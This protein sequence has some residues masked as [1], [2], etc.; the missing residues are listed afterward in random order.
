MSQES[1]LTWWTLN[2]HYLSELFIVVTWAIWSFLVSGTSRILEFFRKKKYV[3]IPLAITM[4]YFLWK[5]SNHLKFRAHFAPSFFS[6]LFVGAYT[7]LRKKVC[8]NWLHFEEKE[9]LKPLKKP[10]VYLEDKRAEIATIELLPHIAIFF[11][12]ENLNFRP[13]NLSQRSHNRQLRVN[14]KVVELSGNNLRKK[15]SHSVESIGINFW[16][17]KS[18][19][20]WQ[21][22]FHL[23]FSCWHKSY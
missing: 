13:L 8:R 19:I 7:L 12:W 20:L 4:N 15:F 14:L 17:T 16:Y 18:L 6:C 1:A 23:F 5:N 3:G 2:S 21:Q 10:R 11:Q 22:L 9:C